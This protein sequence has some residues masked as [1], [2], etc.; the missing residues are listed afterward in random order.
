MEVAIIG[1][2]ASSIMCSCFA[3]DNVKID[4]FEK[5]DKIGKK[6]LGTGN[7]R[8]NLT[9]V[10]MNT[11]FFNAN[12]DK[13][14]HNFSYKETICFFNKI[15]LKTYNDDQGRVYP[16]SNS[17]VSV[18]DV[19]KNYLST[20]TNVNIFTENKVIDIE[21]VNN[22]FKV[23]LEDGA[24]K[25]Y[26]KVVIA[27]GNMLN[28]L[29]FKNCGVNIIPFNPSLCA[30]ETNKNK[31][32]AGVRVSNVAVSCRKVN[33]FET[34][35]ILFRE[36][37]ISGIVVFNLSSYLARIGN[38]NAD[39]FFDFMPN[40]SESQI[41]KELE[42]RRS[43]LKDYKIDNFLT[44]YFIKQLNYDLLKRLK[45]ELNQSVSNLTDSDLQNL[46]HL[47]KNYCLKTIGALSNNQVFSGGID[48]NSLNDNLQVKKCPGLYFTGEAINV[49]GVCGGYN[50]QWAWTSGKIVGENL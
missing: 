18:L 37:G 1:G 34:G 28:F 27:V 50:L 17:A 13:Y 21:R 49:D 41:Y 2:G 26:S 16:F 11:K 45:L 24:Y 31:N 9:N 38:Y 32:L 25:F 44:G 19:L 15:G 10:N 39:V 14:L 6:I 7:G 4:L 35:E 5:S 42:K 46:A 29:T 8:C 40:Y 23:V 36:D 3:K 12:I 43:N 22:K 30:L 47:I 48:L 33:F 20:K